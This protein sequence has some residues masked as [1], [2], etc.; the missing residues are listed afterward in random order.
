M[1]SRPYN[2]ELIL[3]SLPT[4][5]AG[6][7]I[8]I[9]VLYLLSRTVSLW[10]DSPSAI[11]CSDSMTA[12]TGGYS[13]NPSKGE[14]SCPAGTE[15]IQDVRECKAAVQALA[16]AKHRTVAPHYKLPYCKVN[17]GVECYGD[18]RKYCRVTYNTGETYLHTE[19]A[20]T[21]RVCKDATTTAAPTSI[22]QSALPS[23]TLTML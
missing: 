7:L 8:P 19:S 12:G 10:L 16:N 5:I 13:L 11:G 3:S 21:Q 1:T 4:A 20:R 22:N 15:G 14:Y 9:S 17:D 23:A 2:T 6:R 18:R